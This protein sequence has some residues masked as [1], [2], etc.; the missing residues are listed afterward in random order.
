MRTYLSL[1]FVC[2]A[3]LSQ[4][5]Y[6]LLLGVD[7]TTLSIHRLDPQLNQYL[8]SFGSGFVG[9]DSYAIAT[10]PVAGEVYFSNHSHNRIYVFDYSL[11]TYKRSWAPNFT[12]EIRDLKLIGGKLYAVGGNQLGIYNPNG[13][14]VASTTITAT[15]GWGVSVNMANEVVVVGRVAGGSRLYAYNPTTFAQTYTALLTGSVYG[16]ISDPG[17][18][19][20]YYSAATGG[21]DVVYYTNLYSAG[22]T[23]VTTGGLRFELA[24]GHGETRYAVGAGNSLIT[25][26]T[27]SSLGGPWTQVRVSTFTQLQ[28]LGAISVIVAPEPSSLLGMGL[29]AGF[30]LRRRKH[31]LG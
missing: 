20:G 24:A 10:D 12:H 14:T 17:T 19:I 22:S 16:L 31:S 25:F 5:S 18:N 6:E 1:L 4:A 21:G 15:D 11:G 3:G 28:N 7:T 23:A 30:L 2:A 9:A 27:G 13:T 8:G 29:A 26:L